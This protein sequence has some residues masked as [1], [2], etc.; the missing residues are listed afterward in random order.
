VSVHWT[1]KVWAESKASGSTLLVLL[2]L[3]DYADK[4][5]VAWPSLPKL[6]QKARLSRNTVREAIRWAVTNRELRVQSRGFGRGRRTRYL[7]F[8]EIGSTGYP[9]EKGQ[10]TDKKRVNAERGTAPHTPNRQKNRQKNRQE[11]GVFDY[12][13]LTARR[14]LANAIRNAQTRTFRGHLQATFE[15]EYGHLYGRGVAA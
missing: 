5:G 7:M 13:N 6:G 4:D 12:E 9:I 10:S 3:A 14:N 8:P 11:D 2:A 1:A 15:R